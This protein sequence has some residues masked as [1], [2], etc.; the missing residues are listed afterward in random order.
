MQDAYVV[1]YGRAA[2]GKGN[3]RGAYAHT[4][5]D[6]VA[7]QVFIGVIERIEGVSDPG[8]IDEVIVGNAFTESE[9]GHIYARTTALLAELPHPV[10]GQTVNRDYSSGLQTISMAANTIMPGQADVVAA[11]G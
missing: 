3:G 2:T 10:T 5:A 6:D 4:R 1:A 9:Q 7:A 8:L 11:R